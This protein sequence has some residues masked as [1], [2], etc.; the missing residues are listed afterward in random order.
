VPYASLVAG[1]LPVLLLLAGLQLMDGHKLVTRRV[2]FESLA[3]GALAAGLAW[4][5]NRALLAG[6]RVDE[7]LLARVIAPLLEEGLKAAFVGWLVAGGRVGFL[8]DAAICG[9]ATGTGFGL[10]ENLYYAGA[11][12]DPSLPLWLARGLGTAV[13]HGSTTAMFAVL[14]QAASERR[15]SIGPRELL[16]GFALAVAVH[17]AFNLLARDTLLAAAI[18]IA[19]LPLLLV[20]VFQRSERATRDWLGRGLDGEV[21]ALEQIL[22]GHVAGTRIGRYLESLRTRFPSAVVADMLCLLR[23][24]L[25]LSLRAKGMLLARAAGVEL[26]ADESVRSNLEELRYLERAIGA[27]GRLAV[28]PLRRTSRRHLWQIM[29]LSRGLDARPAPA[30]GAP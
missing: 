26:P 18:M 23:I 10:A 11:L 30:R 25:E 4:L 6:A 15:G 12:R 2:L 24:H 7:R 20:G 9:F 29:L 28:L 16:P 3:A 14:T 22:D 5:V 17:A 1:F 8:V 19:A 27:T 21:E 13:M